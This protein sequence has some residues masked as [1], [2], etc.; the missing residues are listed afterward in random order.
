VTALAALVAFPVS[1]AAIWAL[2]RSGLLRWLVAKP[3]AERWH[4]SET[5]LGGGVGIVLGFFAGVAAALATGYL[6]PSRQLWGIVGGCAILFGAGLLDDV[7]DLRPTAKLGVQVGA[8][9]LVMATGTHVEIVGNDVLAW[10][11]GLVWLVGLTNA[12]N[13]LDNMDGLA[14]TLAAIACAFF[15]IDAVASEPSH[16]RLAL[17][18]ALG[19]GCAGFLP[20]NLR[21]GRK[22]LVFMGDSG[23][24]VLGFALAAL[25]L[26]ASYT[27]ATTTVATLI[28]P[29]LILAVPILDT[30]LVTAIRLLDGRP[31]YQGGR[32]HSSHRLVNLGLSETA[33]VV[34]LA[35]VSIAL[36]AT[37][38]AYNVL[39]NGRI[40]AVGVLITFALLVQFGSFLADVDREG[41]AVHEGPLLR[42]VVFAH[43]GRVL[44][45]AVDGALVGASFLAAYLLRFEGSGTVNQRHYFL[46]SLPVLL[47]AR[48]LAFIPFGLYRGVW[49]YAG[50]RDA[51]AAVTAVALSEVVTVGFVTLTQP[52]FG[53]FSS[54]V[55]V[56]DALICSILVGGSRFAERAIVRGL[57]T[58]RDRGGN[59]ILIVG[60]G[61]AGRSLLRELRDT[62]GERVVGFLDDDPRL[63]RRRLQ[64]IAVLG[65]SKEIEA[66][67]ERAHPD[68]VLI[69]IPDAEH[70]RLD[71]IVRA[72]SAARIA[73]RFVR[74]EI[75]LDP[76]VI[77][78]A[79]RE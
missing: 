43:A 4:A 15:A 17:A 34:L 75:D 26:A 62:P 28:L 14:A 70:R 54:S 77:L 31:V 11:L 35:L 21:P 57:A 13:L 12:Y 44:L 30:T 41:A 56:I 63:S 59:R 10:G 25:G 69:T 27:T 51:L 52:P 20:F 7:R 38:L 49:R 66:V 37:S 64:G 16:L 18:L 55:F 45:V 33:A 53:D 67:L 32:D 19:L 76:R 9:L 6:E 40:A 78:G 60:A 50:S 46:L 47:F 71:D 3:S 42:R 24:Q 5:P 39:D 8:A 1:A 65:A 72:C 23:S 58:I 74:R 79:T 73:C 36:G 68:V 61:R 29:I 2:L 48:Y 22:A